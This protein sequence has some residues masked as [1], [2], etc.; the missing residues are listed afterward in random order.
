MSNELPPP[1]KIKKKEE[2]ECL[3]KEKEK[4]ECL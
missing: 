1:K 2:D 3:T 4:L